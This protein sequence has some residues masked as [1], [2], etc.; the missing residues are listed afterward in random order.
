MADDDQELEAWDRI[1]GIPDP[2]ENL[3]LVGYRN[4]LDQLAERYA[5]GRMHHAWLLTGPRGI[6]KATLAARF[7]GHLFRHPDPASAPGHYVQPPDDDPVEGQVARGAH[8]NYLHMRRPW[9]EKDKK[10]RRDLTVEEIRRTVPFFGKSAGRPGWRV[11]VVDTADDLN[12]SA[13]NAL[14]KILEEP[15]PNALFLVLANAPKMLAT[16]RSRCQKIIMRPP[17]KADII[18]VLGHLGF[19]QD[20]SPEDLSL[21]AELSG[22]SVRRAITLANGRGIELYRRFLSITS[23]HDQIPWDLV[24][25][26]AGELAPAE[27]NDR[28]RLLL[29]IVQDT[30]SRRLQG[31]VLPEAAK[32]A[33]GR[34]QSRDLARL[35]DVWEKINRSAQLADAWNLD[36]K[37]VILN[38]FLSLHEAR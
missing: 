16:I 26:L 15:P 7:A 14:L 27:S 37:Q 22:G 6:G 19:A 34:D 20:L 31:A 17:P 33:V 4:I 32:A 24:H 1:E 29:D 28:Y 5:S 21:V 36:R 38:L 11:A 30:L 18:D 23:Q 12:A 13:A 8:P 35:A 3:R 2:L 9:N 10:W 25:G